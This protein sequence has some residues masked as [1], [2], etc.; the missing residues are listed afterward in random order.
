MTL[1]SW[2]RRKTA[3][4]P[5]QVRGVAP[6][7]VFVA[8]LT[9]CTPNPPAADH[10]EQV[11]ILQKIQASHIDANLPA[12]REEFMKLAQTAFKSH[13]KPRFGEVQVKL[14]LLRDGPTQ[15]GVSYPHFYLWAE[16]IR[17]GRTLER[18]AAR[19]DCVERTHIVI[20]DFLTAQE[21]HD[22]PGRVATTFPSALTE[23]V[24][25]HASR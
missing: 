11:E 12:T 25:Q 14:E 16:A 1:N 24:R 3:T 17:S 21:I 22:N 9:A 15:S 18:G 13:F 23:S 8:L 5:E 19:V 7:L 10:K 2:I 6:L 20:T 4:P